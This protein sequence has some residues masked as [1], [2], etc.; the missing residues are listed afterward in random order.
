MRCIAR[1]FGAPVIEPHGKSDFMIR[2]NDVSLSSSPVTV[3]V[4][5]VMVS[6][7]SVV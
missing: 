7:V 1:R 6:Y 2:E 5:C 4:I 3:D